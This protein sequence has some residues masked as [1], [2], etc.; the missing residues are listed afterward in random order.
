MKIRNLH[1]RDFGCVV[2]GVDLRTASETQQRQIRDLVFRKSVV[3]VKNQQFDAAGYES[4]MRLMGSPVPHVLEEYSLPGH[5]NIVTL[6]DH[7]DARGN[8]GGITDGGSFWH[9]DMAYYPKPNILTALYA[10]NAS[11][12]SSS[13]YFIDLQD[14]WNILQNTP[15]LL[16]RIESE[17][18][19]SIAQTAVVHAFGNRRKARQASQAE[20]PLS[21]DRKRDV[22][23]TVHPLVRR[24]AVS[25]VDSLFAIAG[26]AMHLLDGDRQAGADLLDELEDLVVNNANFIEHRYEPGDLV[27]WDNASL[28]H[29]GNVS[30]LTTDPEQA[31]ILWRMNL[32]YTGVSHG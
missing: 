3:I 26:S 13:T 18:G 31:R 2:D 30:N 21:A 29:K 9:S 32:D 25:G 27:I 12:A 17:A 5:R 11:E 1:A 16:E 23:G 24:H 8:S 14:G 15:L 4:R 10:V 28:I 7:I 19:S 6:S 22:G 20:Q